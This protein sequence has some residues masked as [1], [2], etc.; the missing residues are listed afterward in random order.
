VLPLGLYLLSFI[1][2]FDSE[3]WYYRPLFWPLMIGLI[4]Y[5]CHVLDVGVGADLKVQIG[6]LSLGLFA[7]AMVC[8]GELVRLKPGPRRLTAFYLMVAA[9]GA[10]GGVFVTLVAPLIFK[11]YAELQAGIWLTAAVTLVALGYSLWYRTP[12]MW[13]ERL[14][15]WFPAWLRWN[16]I[17][18]AAA[19]LVGLA[20]LLVHLALL[21][22]KDVICTLRNFY[23]VLRVE[24][25]NVDDPER[26]AFWLL[27]GRITHGVQFTGSLR[28]K[29]VSYYGKETG[30]G[31]ALDYYPQ[32]EGMRVWVVGMGTAT[33]AVYGQPGDLYRFF[34]INSNVVR[35]S[36]DLGYFTYITDSQAK[37]EIVMGDARL[38]IEREPPDERFDVLV[39]DAFSSDAIPVHLLTR[40]AFEIYLRHMNPGGIIAVH[41]S[42]R[43]LDLQPVVVGLAKGFDLQMVYR[44][45]T[46]DTYGVD[47]NTEWI[48]LTNNAEFLAR[49]EVQVGAEEITAR[50]VYWTDN[51]SNLFT[52]IRWGQ[53]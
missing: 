2:C 6:G 25:R 19:C 18:L 29:P 48:L 26:H 16:A 7:C 22:Q 9:G 44:E 34:E 11:T 28:D 32:R 33:T 21:E 36:K 20:V 42:N 41:I 15:H 40:E 10:L 50:P 38:S 13:L 5:M 35:L 23:G 14:V 31:L 53:D 45:T 4:A 27:H 37:C 39:L 43:H 52:I 46:P 47:F 12:E 8:H 24:E 3:V 49:S 17:S 30:L 51:F 1:L